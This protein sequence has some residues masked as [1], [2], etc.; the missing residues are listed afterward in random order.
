MLQH[1]RHNRH[2]LIA[3]YNRSRSLHL[4]KRIEEQDFEKAGLLFISDCFNSSLEY[5]ISLLEKTSLKLNLQ[6]FAQKSLF[7][8]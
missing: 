2:L 5:T 7:L 1:A 6:T 3:R 8:L 4:P